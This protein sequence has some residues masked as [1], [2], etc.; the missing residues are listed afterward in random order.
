MRVAVVPTG[1][2]E[3]AGLG[4]ALGVLYPE[5][6]FIFVPDEAELRRPG[7]H[8][9][10][11]PI[12]GFTFN[13]LG[14]SQIETPPQSAVEL[15]ERAA[16]LALGDQNAGMPPADLVVILEDCELENSHQVEVVL[17]V[18]RA[19]TRVH[20]CGIS[21]SFREQTAAALR[22]KVSFHL[23]MP[24][25]EAWFF[26]D[27]RRA[28]LRLAGVP[29]GTPV[30][31]ER[32]RDPEYFLVA[33]VAY[34]Q[35]SEANCPCWETLPQSSQRHRRPKWMQNE[36]R[37]EHPKAY[38]Q[39]L[40]YQ[41]RS[42]TCTGYHEARG[43]VEALKALPWRRVLNRSPSQMRFLRSLVE[44]LRTTLGP[45]AVEGLNP[46]EVARETSVENGISGLLRNA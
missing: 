40:C 31:L 8:G 21:E 33:D 22:E 3:W 27:T 10:A 45:P 42:P 41:P 43:G 11:F 35:A 23:A 4:G 36:R 46:G 34:E 24:M 7:G 14:P 15:I 5:H 44:D 1:Y 18:V 39:W 30:A 17:D 29:V 9:R 12:R 37:T 2:T 6:E 16:Q 28:T 25:L 26:G 19:A 38:L 20:L 13:T 32:A